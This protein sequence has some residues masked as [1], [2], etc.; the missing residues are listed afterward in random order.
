MSKGKCEWC[1]PAIV[2]DEPKD[3][4]NLCDMHAAEYDGISLVQLDRMHE[5]EWMD[6]Q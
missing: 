6:M 5:A 3:P 2:V 4:F 1:V